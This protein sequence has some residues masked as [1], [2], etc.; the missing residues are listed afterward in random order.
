MA[1]FYREK[2]HSS[3]PCLKKK[4]VMK[5]FFKTASENIHGSIS[6]QWVNM[7]EKTFTA[8]HSYCSKQVSRGQ[9]RTGLDVI[10]AILLLVALHY[11]ISSRSV[12]DIL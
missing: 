12:T 1:G 9:R 8:L 4:S 7:T 5:R 2:Q 6:C 11:T 3:V 10:Q